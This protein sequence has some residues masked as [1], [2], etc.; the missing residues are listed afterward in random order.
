VSTN[1][2]LPQTSDSGIP[3]PDQHTNPFPPP[4][5]YA[6]RLLAKEPPIDDDRAWAAY[7]TN[8]SP[9]T[10]ELLLL[11]TA[12][13][14]E[15]Q[16]A[17]ARAGANR[18]RAK[19]GAPPLGPTDTA[20]VEPTPEHLSA[21]ST[22]TVSASALLAEDI[23]PLT[24]IV[25]G[26]IPAGGLGLL[27]AAEK[28]GKSLLALDC[29]QAV[30][31]G[32]P[33]L[34]RA[35]IATNVL[36]VEQEGARAALQGRIKRMMADASPDNLYIR[37]REPADLT[38]PDYLASLQA[39]IVA[40]DIGL[41]FIGPLAQTGN[42]EDENS[43]VAFTE[44]VKSMLDL[45]TATGAS[46]VLIHHRKKPREGDSYASVSSFF[47]TSRGSTALMAAVDFAIGLQR[48]Q[49]EAHGKISAMLRDAPSSIGY[50]TFDVETL[51]IAA[52]DEMLISKSEQHL[53]AL[54][55]YLI[56]H[57]A[58]HSREAIQ[59]AIGFSKATAERTL[60]TGLA[61]YKLEKLGAGNKVPISSP[62]SSAHGWSTIPRQRTDPG[63]RPRGR[64][65]PSSASLPPH[66]REQ[67]EADDHHAPTLILL[68]SKPH[69]CLPP[70]H[71]TPLRGAEEEEWSRSMDFPLAPQAATPT[72]SPRQAARRPSNHQWAAPRPHS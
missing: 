65:V 58:P 70:P 6:E 44:I 49:E 38:D 9:S 37:H 17:D 27:L 45:I 32:N 5:G 62:P 4:Q 50:Y 28:T 24:W 64:V 43:A 7:Y 26:M 46:V 20:A 22:G 41:A 72:G 66:P 34:A 13:A 8:A 25:D 67:V 36:I 63:S 71:R 31:T 51:R 61:A 56:E 10:R 2:D 69:R 53:S 14:L 57:T 60:R 1:T 52:T 15:Q 19:R 39:F 12:K 18:E 35:T 59:T 40:H 48:Q 16:A 54:I 30:A 21:F 33:F 23:P 29:G 3:T 42:I 55:S 47:N 11:G 68:T